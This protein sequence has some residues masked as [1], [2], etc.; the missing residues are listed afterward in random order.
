MTGNVK[1]IISILGAF[2]VAAGLWGCGAAANKYASYKEPKTS[3]EKNVSPPVSGAKT[4]EYEK[5]IDDALAGEIDFTSTGSNSYENSEGVYRIRVVDDDM[6][7]VE[8]VMVQFCSDVSCKLGK[9]DQEGIATFDDPPAVYEV[10]I[11]KAPDGY[12]EN[13][14]AYKTEPTYS[15]MVIVIEKK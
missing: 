7:P 3:A 9:T 15:N 10:H 1:R 5:M 2:A 8:G 6:E 12:D 4:E 11:L 14:N 13:T